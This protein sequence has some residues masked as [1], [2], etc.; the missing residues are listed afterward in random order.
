MPGPTL[1]DSESILEVVNRQIAEIKKKIQLSEG[2][3][4]AH[5]EECDAEKKRNIEKIRNLKKTIKQLQLQLGKPPKCD[6]SIL[7][8]SNKYPKETI[9]LRNKETREAAQLLDY[10]VIDLQKKLDLIRYHAQMHQK[11]MKDLADEYQ[12]LLINTAN[13]GIRKQL[14]PRGK[15]PR[16]RSFQKLSIYGSGRPYYPCGGYCT[17]D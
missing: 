13:E 7:K 1:D 2:Q 9:A 10:K 3:R 17:D 4:K 15:V 5:Y 8:T 16:Q 12:E 6:E 14:D 11:R